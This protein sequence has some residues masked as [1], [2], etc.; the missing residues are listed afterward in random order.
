[1]EYLVTGGAGFIGSN[2]TNSLITE[3]HSVVVVDDLSMG[4]ISNLQSHENLTFIKGSVTDYKL[5]EQIYQRYN[6]DYIFYLAAVASVA[7]SII[8]PIETH[9]INYDSVLRNLDLIKTYQVNLSRFIFSSS[10]AVYGDNEELP[11]KENS[12]IKPLN[13]YAV[14]KYAA[15]RTVVNSFTLYGIKTTAVR[16]FNVFGQNQNPGSPYS[17]VISIL[18]DNYKKLKNKENV[19]FNVY[20]DGNQTRDFIYVK[21]VILALKTIISTNISLGKVY[22]IGTGKKTSL[23]DIIKCFDS[24][25]SEKL[26]I[27]F[28]DKRIGDIDHSLADI[29]KLSNL[30]FKC[31]YSTIEG[32]QELV[33][34]S[35]R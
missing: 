21:D 2:L 20:G 23:N 31:E 28:K 35:Q 10:A 4:K 22:N 24:I 26:P 16:F 6:F 15:E 8:R 30:G 5:M 12:L 29:S 33:F 11:K 27:E 25:Y 14:D 32:L 1:M 17:G 34:N 9:S 19:V 7:D 18:N 3:G 13:Q